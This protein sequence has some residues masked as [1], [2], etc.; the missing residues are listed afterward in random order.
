MKKYLLILS[1]ALAFLLIGTYGYEYY[2]QNAPI[3]SLGEKSRELKNHQRAYLQERFTEFQHSIATFIE[4]LSKD[5]RLN[6]AINRRDDRDSLFE[7]LLEGADENISVEIHDSLKNSVAWVNRYGG[8][9]PVEELKASISVAVI[10]KPLFSYLA[11]TLPVGPAG[12]A[13]GYVTGKR[14]IEVNLP[15]SN[16]FINDKTFS[17]SFA[18]SISPKPEFIFNGS[19][20][21]LGELDNPVELTGL[22]GRSLGYAV[23]KAPAP[24][25]TPS[26]PRQNLELIRGLLLILCAVILL[27]FGWRKIGDGKALR[28]MAFFTAIVWLVRYLLIWFKIPS[29]VAPDWFSPED[30]ASPFG[31]GLAYSLGDFFITSVFILLNVSILLY[32][33]LRGG[34]R[35]ADGKILR[36][37]SIVIFA[38]IFS[39]LLRAIF[40]IN[41]SA[42]FDS[43]VSFNDLTSL[44]PAPGPSL[45]LV[46]LLM[47]VASFLLSGLMAAGMIRENITAIL[48]GENR[49]GYSWFLTALI[50][51]PVG[52]ILGWQQNSPIPPLGVGSLVTV[53]LVAVA[54]SIGKIGARADDGRFFKMG[55]VIYCLSMAF[56]VLLLRQNIEKKERSSIENF[57]KGITKPT[58]SWLSFLVN[59]TLAQCTDDE[60]VRA[61]KSGDRI[62]Y[63]ALAF[64]KWGKSL[65]S[66]EGN[67]CLI[68]YFNVF[69]E[70]IS[71]FNIGL[72]SIRENIPLL[73]DTFSLQ[74]LELGR[75][76]V[77]QIA[78]RRQSAHATIKDSSGRT[79]GLVMVEVSGNKLTIL[80]GDVPEILR[81]AQKQPPT[82]LE[83]PLIFAE[84][85]DDSLVLTTDE[86]LYSGGKLRRSVSETVRSRSSSW[87]EEEY[88]GRSYESYYLKD[89]FS[90]PGGGSVFLLTRPSP[91]IFLTLYW[92]IRI[93]IL[94]TII[95][96][97]YISARIIW[98][99]HLGKRKRFTFAEKLLISYV[100]VAAFP[101]IFFNY[102]NREIASEMQEDDL[103]TQL[104]NQTQIVASELKTR[105]YLS[106]RGAVSG[107]Y[108]S[109]CSALADDLDIDFDLFFQ[110]ELSATSKPELYD[111]EIIDAHIDASLYREV[112]LRKALF[113]M[114]KKN[115][116]NIRYAVGSRPLFSDDGKIVAV[117]SVP[118]LLKQSQHDREMVQTNALIFSLFGIGFIISIIIGIILSKQFGSPIRSLIQATREIASGNISYKKSNNRRDE[119]GELEKAFEKMSTDLRDKQDQ[120]IAANREAAWREMAK[121][122]AHEIKNP[123]TPMKLSLQ[124]LRAAFRDRAANLDEIAE[125]VTSTTLEQINTLSK[126]AS[127]FSQMAKMP[128]RSIEKVDLHEIITEAADLFSQYKEVTIKLTKK[129]PLGAISADREEL[130]R[131]FVNI[132]KNSIQAMNERGDII[133]TT[134]VM[135]GGIVIKITDDGPGI[136]REIMDHLFEFNFSTKTEGMG[137]GLSLVKKTIN[138]FGGSIEISSEQGLGTVVTINFK[139]PE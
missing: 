106:S 101:V 33:F 113:Y 30:Y 51:V 104:Q 86:R 57:S 126:I 118:T 21:G 121:Q 8:Q 6:N 127:E 45:L 25:E 60:A 136:T 111:S 36:L 98:R 69:G 139:K 1:T 74:A 89:E 68:Q 100:I 99:T 10:Q 28:K 26:E 19:L 92:V 130:R 109:D 94:F 132:F 137:I 83:Q 103:R 82:G 40:V 50:L 27:P 122:V 2:H 14:L 97:I 71:N 66:G 114:Q 61:I 125:K 128:E 39:L 55:L 24:L 52:I 32:Y 62:E 76:S 12:R 15:L 18:G 65:L 29:Y 119:F 108:D 112:Y 81:T 79:V 131:A 48:K 31:Y 115:I 75:R 93:F 91:G 63:S 116:G 84:F 95:L 3:G 110:T 129:S 38:T 47:N 70:P 4:K 35:I 37:A 117:L 107:L 88:G 22:D 16:R 54:A 123:L 23:M 44:L 78:M 17:N 42:V 124:H 43:T 120:L 49:N 64:K 20:D 73:N 7:I 134:E 46:S 105:Y 135:A 11:V 59:V 90:A 9:I 41:Q 67:N 133:V 102:Y 34:S 5:Q 87:E 53:I 85:L 138:D 58:D 72:P 80:H 13:T 56:T 77:N 96:G